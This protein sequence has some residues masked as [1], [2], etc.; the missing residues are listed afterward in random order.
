[1]ARL[2][3]CYMDYAV[4]IDNNRAEEMRTAHLVRNERLDSPVFSGNSS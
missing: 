4:N 1:M 2:S 3:L